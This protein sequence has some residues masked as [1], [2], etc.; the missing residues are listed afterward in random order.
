MAAGQNGTAALLV[1][2]VSQV[3]WAVSQGSSLNLRCWPVD[4]HVYSQV[5]PG[6]TLMVVCALPVSQGSSLRLAAVDC[7]DNMHGAA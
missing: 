2:Y 5:T 3:N 6:S 7:Y 1:M 4:Y